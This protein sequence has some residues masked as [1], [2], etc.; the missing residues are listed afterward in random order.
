MKKSYC[1]IFKGKILHLD[2]TAHNSLLNTKRKII[3]SPCKEP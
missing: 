3:K 2:K 1:D